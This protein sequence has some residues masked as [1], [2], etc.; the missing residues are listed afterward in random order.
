L[1]GTGTGP[2]T[3]E[4]SKSVK[5]EA[6]TAGEALLATTLGITLHN[7]IAR[8]N[9]WTMVRGTS[10][11]RDG[12]GNEGKRSTSTW[13]PKNDNEEVFDMKNEGCRPSQGAADEVG[14]RKGSAISQYKKI[15]RRVTMESRDLPTI[16]SPP[17]TITRVATK[18]R[19]RVRGSGS[20]SE[21]AR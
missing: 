10:V 9:A 16:A 20:S 12:G 4:V 18:S 2:L 7:R 11:C 17:W 8:K 6:A 5:E 19:A 14:R 21:A 3:Q 1:T 13:A 15:L